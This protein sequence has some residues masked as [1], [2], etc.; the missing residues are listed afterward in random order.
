MIWTGIG[1]KK[2]LCIVNLYMGALTNIIV[3]HDFMWYPYQNMKCLAFHIL[4]R[5][6]HEM[7]IFNCLMGKNHTCH[8]LWTEI[9]EINQN[10]KGDLIKFCEIFTKITL[11]LPQNNQKALF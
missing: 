1:K 8:N 6:P 5:M 7:C 10:F 4:I 9:C 2:Q 11:E 3:A